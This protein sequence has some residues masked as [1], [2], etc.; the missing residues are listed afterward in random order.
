VEKDRTANLRPQQH[1]VTRDQRATYNEHT[2]AIIW[3][4]GLSGAGK[5]TLAMAA[6]LDL[7][8]AGYFV[9]ALDGDNVRSGLNRDLGFSAADRSENIRRVAEVAALFADSGAVVITA[10][11]SPHAADR[12]AARA[13][14][15]APFFEV[16]L[17]ADVAACEARDP[18]GLY[19]RA[20]AQNIPDFTGV[21][22]PYDIPE[23]ADL[24][25]DTSADT[26][27]RCVQRLTTLIRRVTAVT[28]S[29]SGA[30]LVTG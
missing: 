22:A 6:E 20:R 13:I 19:A 17:S 23:H 10:F 1:L 29:A 28:D 30:T 14:A 26:I 3:L 25:L 5:S 12:A 4:T 9:Y 11:I 27:P 18:K 8:R 15:N 2:G 7:C 16:H 24:V 21:S